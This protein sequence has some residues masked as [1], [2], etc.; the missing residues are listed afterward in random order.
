[1]NASQITGILRIFM[2]VLVGIASKYVGADTVNTIGSILAA[3][4]AAGGWSAYANSTSNLTQTVAGIKDDKGRD[5]LKILVSSTAPQDLLK[6]ASNDEVPQ[7]VHAAS[8][9]PSAPPP[10]DPYVTRRVS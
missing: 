2:P 4:V 6:L 5:A 1:M 7:V 9:A 10:K 8:V 3:F